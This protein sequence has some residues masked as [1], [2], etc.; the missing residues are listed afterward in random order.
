MNFERFCGMASVAMILL[1]VTLHVWLGLWGPVWQAAWEMKPAD[2][3]GIT[4]AVI[5][6]TVT[7]AVG[8]VAYV[9]ALK[10]I[11]LANQQIELQQAQIKENREELRKS[12]H[13]RL[14]RE[15][16]QFGSDIDRLLTAQSYLQKFADQF[17]P[18]GNLDGW[19][20]QLFFSRRDAKDFISAS[21]VS[22]PFGFGPRIATVMARAQRLG[23]MI[24][25]TSPGSMPQA[26]ILSHYESTVKEAVLGIRSVAAG[27]AAEIPVR[28]A[29]LVALADERDSYAPV[30]MP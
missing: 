7:I 19:S 13:A 20:R 12:A 5:G 2:A 26:G 6:W 21:A 27:I 3:L 10:Q 22:A 1:I 29:Q 30:A 24:A 8:A 17:P 25:A 14:E 18:E 11:R 16:L 9:A 23:D 4:V 28:R 15:F